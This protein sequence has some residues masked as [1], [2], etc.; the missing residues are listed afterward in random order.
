MIK[1]TDLHLYL[2]ESP[3]VPVL[4]ASIDDFHFT[5]VREIEK[6]K[7]EPHTYF[8][9]MLTGGSG[10]QLIYFSTLFVDDLNYGKFKSFAIVNAS[11]ASSEADFTLVDDVA[12]RLLA[13]FG[14][15]LH[16]PQRIERISTSY[17]LSGEQYIA[18]KVGDRLA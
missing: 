5:F 14:G 8:Y 12:A 7:A 15:H 1:D 4:E 2:N 17:F 18:Q 10:V 13:N 6:T 3:S 16:N 11:Q 9:S